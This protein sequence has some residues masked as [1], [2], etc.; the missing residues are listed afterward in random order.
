VGHFIKKIIL[1]DWTKPLANLPIRP[2]LRLRIR[3]A[4]ILAE[5]KQNGGKTKSK[6][7]KLLRKNPQLMTPIN[8]LTDF[9]R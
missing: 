6:M 3:L 8:H 1:L 2:K 5:L 4:F 9:I 7:V